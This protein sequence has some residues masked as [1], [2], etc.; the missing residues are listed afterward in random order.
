MECHICCEGINVR[1]YIVNCD[2]CELKGCKKCC[3][4]YLLES[5]DDPHCM[6]CRTGWNRVFLMEH[7]P[8]TF[9]TKHL[10]NHREDVLLDREK[11]LLP[12]SQGYVDEYLRV[13][14]VIQIK[15]EIRQ[16]IKR[17]DADVRDLFEKIEN[18]PRACIVKEYE[19]YLEYRHQKQ[20]LRVEV[21]RLTVERRKLMENMR[22]IRVA[23]SGEVEGIGK[24]R[25]KCPLDDC[26]GYLGESSICG[27]CEKKVCKKCMEECIE[28]HVCNPETV[29]TVKAIKKESRGCPGCGTM[30]SKIDGCDQ[31]WC[32]IPTCHTAFSWR[33]GKPIS[34]HIHNPHYI[35]FQNENASGMNR[36]IRD[37]PCGGM[38]DYREVIIA[39]KGL[40]MMPIKGRVAISQ[41]MIGGVHMSTNHIIHELGR[42]Q[43]GPPDNGR[44][45][46]KYLL[47]EIQEADL[48]KCLQMQEKKREK[49]KAFGDILAMFTHT[50]TDIFRNILQ[51]YE[52]YREEWSNAFD[53]KDDDGYDYKKEYTIILKTSQERAMAE[54]RTIERLTEYTIQHFQ[55]TARVYQCVIPV[56]SLHVFE[57]TPDGFT[58][59]LREQYSFDVTL[60]KAFIGIANES[61][62][63]LIDGENTET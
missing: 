2:G 50:M 24:V 20:D 34:G 9:V 13:K 39:V 48:K 3:E 17:I 38:P 37:I 58:R 5:H 41:H 1:N 60:R 28:G 44:L 51:I 61:L 18:I 12:S 8:K 21:H 25:T 7:F 11:S 22:D 33:T 15:N 10:K 55:K 40:R 6:G 19:K 52:E 14:Q 32:T 31:M 63:T 57:F 35:Q 42:F 56:S 59:R 62:Y 30:V 36:N 4:R 43:V 16:E 26:R 47:K 49:L 27:V 29:E 45:R 54:F 23:S 46:A 53:R